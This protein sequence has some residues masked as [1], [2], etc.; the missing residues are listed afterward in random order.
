MTKPLAAYIVA[1]G[2]SIVGSAVG[3]V[4]VPWLVLGLGKG[5]D[6]LAVIFAVEAL[7][8]VV[9]AVA[10]S[11]FVDRIDKR[12]Q[13]IGG[14]TVLAVTFG[15]LALLYLRHVLTTT[16]LIII[17]A[18]NGFIGGISG[19]AE[20]A[21]VPALCGN[22]RLSNHRVNGIV[23]SLHTSC[24]L[25][26][27]ILGGAIIAL[28]GVAWALR[29]DGSS[30]ALAAAIF[31]A[32]IPAMRVS[33][34][35]DRGSPKSPVSERLVGFRYIFGD[36][37]LGAITAV[38]TVVNMAI[39]PMLLLLIPVTVKHVGGSALNVGE[40][41]SCFGFGAVIASLAYSWRGAKVQPIRSLLAS[42]SI[43]VLCFIAVTTNMNWIAAPILVIIGICVGYMGPLESSVMQNRAWTESIARVILAYM[44]MRTTF[45]PVGFLIDGWLL[46]LGGPHLAL[47]VTAGIFLIP[48]LIMVY[49]ISCH[50]AAWQEALR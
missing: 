23:G 16:W 17:F 43:L 4:A 1:L 27:P 20:S 38:S 24:D 14:N 50:G 19:A 13:S 12:L 22:S 35:S 46:R 25:V 45:V 36:P 3:A 30:Y 18:V 2:L 49:N 32:F 44:A 8:A 34:R 48:L 11:G 15:M 40:L 33:A 9:A 31:A 5:P 6:Q 41:M 28:M 39:T 47:D 10:A 42:L 21:M 26:G 7:L 37:V 29:M